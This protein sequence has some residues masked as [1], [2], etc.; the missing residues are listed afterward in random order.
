MLQ[1]E[2]P[3]VTQPLLSF[4]FGVHFWSVLFSRCRK[5]EKQ[6]AAY[7]KSENLFSKNGFCGLQMFQFECPRVTHPLLSFTFR[8]H[9]CR[10]FSVDAGKGKHSMWL[11]KKVKI[12]FLKIGFVDFKCFS[13]NDPGSHTPLLSFTFG[14]NSGGPF[15]WMQEKGNAACGSSK[16]SK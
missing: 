11:I 15:Q 2:C 14:A 3:R 13:M 1:F 5:R 12:Y 7:Q 6:H 10:A 9:S 8:V 16:M 4:M